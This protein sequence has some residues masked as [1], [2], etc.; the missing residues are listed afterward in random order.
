MEKRKSRI[1][2]YDVTYELHSLGWK[3]FQDLCATIISEVLGQTVQVFLPS[4]DG[5]RDGAFHGL[6]NPEEGTGLKGSFTVQCKFTSKRDKSLSLTQ[7]ADELDKARL[8]ASR[9][10][11]KNYIIMSNYQ[12]SG[13]AEEKIRQA[14]LEIDGISSFLLLGRE[15]ITFK[16]RESPRLRMLVPRVYGLGDLSQ[17]LDER[18]YIQ[19]E[20]ILS[21]MRQDL[22]KF[23]LTNPHRRS[24]EALVK[25]GFV[26][27]L[28][29]PA[30]GKSIIAASLAIG[31]IDLWGCATLKIR[32]A[33]DFMRHWNPNEPRQFFWVDD[34]FGTTQYQRDASNDWN[35]IFPAMHGAIRKGAR[36]I[37]TSRDY[38]FRAAQADLKAYAFPLLNESQVVI[39]VQELTKSEKEQILYNHIKLGNQPVQFRTRIKPLLPEVADSPHFLPEIARRLGDSL[40]TKNL[41]INRDSI[42]QFVEQPLA[43]LLEIVRTLDSES[44]AAL[45]LIF[46]AGGFLESPIVLTNEGAQTLCLLGGTEAG[47]R[48]ALTALDG[49][50]VKLVQAGGTRC[51]TFKHPTVGDAFA[52]LI[53]ENPELLDIYLAGTPTQKLLQEITCGD[54]GIEGA[55]VIIPANRYE[56]LIERLNTIDSR[57]KLYNFLAW[58]CDRL[59]LE[60]FLRRHQYIQQDIC[61]PGSY[62]HAYAKVFLL[63][64]LHELDL[65]HEDYRI[66]FVEKVQHLAVETPDADFLSIPKIRAVFKE[67]EIDEILKA[68]RYKLLPNISAEIENWEFNY[69]PSNSEDPEGY[70][71]TLKESLLTFKKELKDDVEGKLLIEDALK[72]IENTIESLI[73]TYF[74]PEPDYDDYGYSSSSSKSSSGDRSIFDDVDQ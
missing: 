11:A 36:V 63:A 46:M 10:L 15:W 33:D 70:F 25:H 69:E 67:S 30:S 56:A 64:R 44:R 47:V 74:E 66:Q 7:L 50:L 38:I 1:Q 40:F 52:S 53:A 54:M 72:E 14:F 31:A 6:W 28:G 23:V 16:I 2:A 29:E 60:Q 57:S 58:R 35:R 32:N 34:A 19:A 26:L 49:S 20:E 5:G 55:R 61:S 4:R 39:N 48:Q 9:D 68:V 65:L 8:L 27:L 41:N 73:E 13:T 17:I 18:A 43:F 51:W 62:L 22:A 42:M 21:S 71:E 37:F 45:A 12:V 3:A 24:A 59:F